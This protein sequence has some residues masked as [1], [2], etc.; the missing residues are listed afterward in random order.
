MVINSSLVVFFVTDVA[1]MCVTERTMNVIAAIRLDSGRLTART[2][3]HFRTLEHFVFT[4]LANEVGAVVAKGD[5]ISDAAFDGPDL[6]NLGATLAPAVVNRSV[7]S[8]DDVLQMLF[9]KQALCRLVMSSE[10][11]FLRN[12]FAKGTHEMRR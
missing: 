12:R 4:L 8:S 7:H 5:P 9:M 2:F 3:R 10:Y 11:L 6:S 1:P